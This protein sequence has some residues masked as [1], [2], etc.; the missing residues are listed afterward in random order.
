MKERDVIG[1]KIAVF[2]ESE[3]L[4]KLL[5]ELA[6]ASIEVIKALWFIKMYP[7][8]ISRLLGIKIARELADVDI[9]GRQT[10]RRIYPFFDGFFEAKQCLAL[11]HNI[12]QATEAK[13]K[14]ENG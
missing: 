8:D 6:E 2:T 13:K 10:L 11:K 12:P 14:R 5:E 3:C 4:W 1:D 9:A 7:R